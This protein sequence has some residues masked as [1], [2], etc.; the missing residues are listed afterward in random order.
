[1]PRVGRRRGRKDLEG[2]FSASGNLLGLEDNAQCA[3]TDLANQAII[4]QPRLWRELREGQG[5][6]SHSSEVAGCI[7]D[8]LK[9]IETLGQRAG[10]RTVASEEVLARGRPP[11]PA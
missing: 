5:V 8:E 3:A 1:M 7:L 6:G 2:H 9:T 10:D 11:C 4:T